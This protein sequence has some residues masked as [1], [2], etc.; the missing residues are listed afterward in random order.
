MVKKLQDTRLAFTL[1]EL[2]VVIAIIAILAGMLLP[3]LTKVKEKGQ[4]ARCI[5]NLRQI[6]YGTQM[7]VNDYGDALPG[8]CGVVISKRFYIT[9]RSGIGPGPIELLGYIAPY[10]G[11]RLPPKNSGIYST[12]EVAICTSFAQATKGTNPYSYIINQHITNTLTPLDVVD[13]PFGRTDPNQIPIGMA[14]APVKLATIKNLTTAWM[15]MDMDQTVTSLTGYGL[16]KKPVH[17]N[18]YWNRLYLDGHVAAIKD[19]S[20]FYTP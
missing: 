2:L 9:D 16:P 14:N 5:N 3:V 18:P 20:D 11:L 7:Y 12:G 13:Y 15:A 6:G 17:G 19:R 4:R 10:I 1:I 8:P